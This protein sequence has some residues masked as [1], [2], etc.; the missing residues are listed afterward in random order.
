MI[1][2]TGGWMVGGA[3][4]QE[5]I[6]LILDRVPTLRGQER[7][8][9]PLRGGITNQNY[10]VD[11]DNK[12]FVL[13]IGSDNTELLGIDRS[14][15]YACS[16][17]AAELGVGTEV[18]DFLPE[19]GS[20]VM[21]FA[22]GRLLRPSDVAEPLV[23]G[24]IVEAL[25]RYHEGPAGAGTFSPFE[26]VRDYYAV[27][28]NRQVAFPPVIGEAMERLD[29]I[30]ATLGTDGPPCPCHN[31]LFSSN[32]ID[33]GSTVR[34]IDWEYGGM[35]DRMFDLGNL[36]ANNGFD[37]TQERTLLELYFGEVRPEQIRKLR[38]MRLASDIR[39]S[40]WGF[41]QAGISGLDY[42]FLHYGRT[43]LDRFLTGSEAMGIGPFSSDRREIAGARSLGRPL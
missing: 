25:R 28:W 10:L 22:R 13:R 15:E 36:A 4:I 43:H 27:A 1:P 21:G 42:E 7:F 14:V 5:Q 37:E 9:I 6:D 29:V 18:I 19:F 8:V 11:T 23:L 35:G 24:R 30:E 41:L 39:E 40:M 2:R 34:I 12:S 16:L 20:I 17:A 3:L 33:D 38:F 32:L 26:V 31:D